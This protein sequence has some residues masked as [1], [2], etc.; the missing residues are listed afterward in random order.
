MVTLKKHVDLNLLKINLQNNNILYKDLKLFPV[1]NL[2][3][4]QQI[5]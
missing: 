4:K 5:L 2:T 3:A 1:N